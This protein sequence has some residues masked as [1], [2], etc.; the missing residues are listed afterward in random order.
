MKEIVC[1]A[2]KWVKFLAQPID[3]EH[4]NNQSIFYIPVHLLYALE[5]N[6]EKE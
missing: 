3:D 6:H 2:K 5:W 4:Y 1:T